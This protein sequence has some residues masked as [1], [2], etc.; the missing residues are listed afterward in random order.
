MNVFGPHK[1]EMFI[2][3]N[4]FDVHQLVRVKIL[5]N[6]L[7]VRKSVAR[8]IEQSNGA[9]DLIGVIYRRYL[10]A[11]FVTSVELSTTHNLVPMKKSLD[12]S[13]RVYMRVQGW[14]FGW[15]NVI[16]V[17]MEQERSAHVNCLRKKEIINNTAYI[18]RTNNPL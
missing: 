17:T 3:T 10:A 7:N 16:S 12:R 2:L 8:A 13:V 9:I 4:F 6:T 11:V 18:P 15:I 5:N 1:V 14:F